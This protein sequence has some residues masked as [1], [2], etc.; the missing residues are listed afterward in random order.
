M[1]EMEPMAGRPGLRA[2]R[3]SLQSGGQQK[4]PSPSWPAD[5]LCSGVLRK[6]EFCPSLLGLQG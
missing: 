6:L 5:G 3:G 1:G 4:C 2:A